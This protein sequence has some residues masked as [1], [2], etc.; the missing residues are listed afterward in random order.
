[1]GDT[2]SPRGPSDRPQVVIVGGPN[3]AGKSTIAPEVVG[4]VLGIGEFVNADAIAVGLSGFD[5]ERAAMAA[6]RVMLTRLRELAA[7]RADFAFESTLASRTFAPWLRSL[8][9][10]GYQVSLAYVWLGS[11]SLAIQRVRARVRGGG[12]SIPP[13]VV[14]RRY[15]RSASNAASLYMPL[16]DSWRLYDNSGSALALVAHGG[17]EQAPTILNREVFEA[18]RRA[19]HGEGEHGEDGEDG[20]RADA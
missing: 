18:F 20:G 11:A 3:G 7:A 1:M 19:S 5:P 8:R 12:H 6:G 17:A 9:Q 4:R 15:V 14:R 2:R 13:E 10:S 16:A